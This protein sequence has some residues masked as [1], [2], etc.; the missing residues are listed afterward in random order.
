MRT[1]IESWLASHCAAIDG[2]L[3]AAVFLRTGD[4][5]QRMA[6]WPSGSSPYPS[7]LPAAETALQRREPIAQGVG[8]GKRASDLQLIAHPL[9]VSGVIVGA[10]VMARPSSRAYAAPAQAALAESAGRFGSVMNERPA[11][12]VAE[13]APTAAPA[14][15]LS[16]DVLAMAHT[17][18][19]QKDFRCAATSVLSSLAA[20]LGCDR[21]SLGFRERGVTRV[22]AVSDGGRIDSRRGAF[23]EIAAAMDEA[24]DEAATIVYPQPAG[25]APRIVAAH[26]CLARQQGLDGVCSVPLVHG[27]RVVGA[28][29]LELSRPTAPQPAE[30]Q[31]AELL[32]RTIAPWLVAQRDAAQP[33]S[34]RIAAAARQGVDRLAKPG[35][36]RFKLAAVAAAALIAALLLVPSPQEVSAQARLEGTTQRAMAAPGDGFLKQVFVRPGDAVREGQV[37]VEFEGEDLRV[38][39]QRL[40]AEMAGQDASVG[41]AMQRQD[42]SALA[43][44]SAKVDELK[45]EL[46]ALDQ[47]LDRAQMK[48][49]FDGIVIEGDL[50]QA[51]GAPVKRGD[52]LLKLAPSDGFRAMV[53]VDDADIADIA[54]G[55]H[56]SIV[57]TAHPDQ[58]WPMTVARI[59]P[60][61]SALEGRTVFEVEVMLDA[62]AASSE[63]LRP[64]M[65]GVARLHV[66]DRPPAITWTREAIAWVRLAAWRWIG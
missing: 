18:F 38:E 12:P 49:P 43:I 33:L 20:R 59:T 14:N 35:H 64:G 32:A 9:A 29:V 21:A 19:E 47:R 2:V 54:E 6:A 66:G 44:A 63:R 17:A 27:G 57:L 26:A 56:G 7:L 42:M 61:A 53:E 36:G 15:D 8:T 39:R 46:A 50:T 4:G 30:L 48:A 37:L 24:I 31:F 22:E 55:Q 25:E 62:S 5:L 28:I 13:A 34:R 23:P 1:A 58:A 10:V 60:L 16:A 45:A 51:L 52:L 40:V 11:A 65:R 3:I 41:D